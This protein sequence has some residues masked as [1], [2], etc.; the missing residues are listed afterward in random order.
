MTTIA[1]IGAGLMGTGLARLF[2][3]QGIAVAAFDANPDALAA[4]IDQVPATR[5]AGSLAEAAAPADIVIEAVSERLDLKQSI[6]ADLASAT[7]PNT[8]LATNSSVIAVGAITA[9]LDDASAARCVGTHFWN[10]PD[11]IPLVEVIEGPRTAPATIETTVAIMAAAGKEPVHVR[12]DTVPGNR[13]QHALWREAIALVEEG[14]C[15]AE[16]VDRLVKRSFGLRLP[17]LGP[18]ENA[19]LVGLELTKAIHEVVLPTLS[20]A[21]AASPILS[22]RIAQGKTGVAT[23]QGLY[24]RWTET[25]VAEVRARL[26]DHLAALLDQ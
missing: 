22:E 24:H 15:S 18:L 26:A 4:L 17:V 20:R 8:I 21:T 7:G 9:K 23:G 5:A 13:L 11:L 2:T 1:L 14:V 6:F 10:P 19:D 12:R 25:S 16:D 3:I